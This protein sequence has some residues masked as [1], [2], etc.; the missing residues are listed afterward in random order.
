MV[1]KQ[2]RFEL[3]GNVSAQFGDEPWLRASLDKLGRDI[4]YIFTTEDVP[5]NARPLRQRRAVAFVKLAK[6]FADAGAS[7]IVV[8]WLQEQR[9][10]LHDLDKGVLLPDHLCPNYIDSPQMP[11]RELMARAY[12]ANAVAVL[13]DGDSA[14]NA[15][16]KLA[17]KFPALRKALSPSSRD[18]AGL[19]EKWPN[20]FSKD[21]GAPDGPWR[22]IFENRAAVIQTIRKDLIAAGREPTAGSIAKELIDFAISKVRPRKA[23]KQARY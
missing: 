3:T 2:D 7:P 6:F 16:K 5:E 1:K 15:A 21:D 11:S 22:S 14:T 13:A 9:M 8:S 18:F 17:K 20:F 19:I 12:V 4:E 23:K 10:E